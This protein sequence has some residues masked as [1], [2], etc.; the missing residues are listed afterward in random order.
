MAWTLQSVITMEDKQKIQ[1]NIISLGKSHDTSF[2]P[3]TKVVFH[4]QTRLCDEEKTLLD[5]S[6]NAQKPMELILGKQFKLD[7]WEVCVQMMSVGEISSFTVDKSLVTPYPIVAR[8][9]RDSWSNRKPMGSSHCCGMMAM[10][11]EGL[12]YPDLDKLMKKPQNLEFI[13]DLISVQLPGHYEQESWAMTEDEKLQSVAQLRAEGN[14]LYGQ[15]L[16]DQA[17]TKYSEALGRLEQLQLR[18]K[19][20]DVEW[21]RLDLIKIPLLLNFSQCKLIAEDYYPVIEHCTTVVEKDPDNVKALFRRAKAHAAVWNFTDSRQDYER[22]RE[23]DASLAGTIRRELEALD[24][25]E[26]KKDEED[27]AKFQGKMFGR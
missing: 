11:A 14:K 10:Q 9:L 3:G 19:P 24:I 25:Q 2:V 23:L 12:G 21:L 20:R 22:V 16:F 8:T 6:R 17:S 26:K 7:V 13:I 4:F 5:D 1:K 15:K 27:R 18:E